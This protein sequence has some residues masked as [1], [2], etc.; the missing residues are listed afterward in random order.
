MQRRCREYRDVIHMLQM[1]GT[2]EFSE[3]AQDLYGS[4]DDAFYAGA[5]TLKDLAHTV[6]NIIV[7]FNGI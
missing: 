3:I 4:S 2:P 7:P 1:R 5:P 6:L